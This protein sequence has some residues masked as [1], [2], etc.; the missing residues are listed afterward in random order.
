MDRKFFELSK[1]DFSERGTYQ[2]IYDL[3]KDLLRLRCEDSVFRSQGKV[4]GTVLSSEAFLLRFFGQ[5]TD[6]LLLVNLG[7][8]L[9][10]DPAPEPLLVPPLYKVWNILLSSED[11]KYGD[12]GTPPLDTEENLRISGHAAVAMASGASKEVAHWVI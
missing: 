2:A 6:R 3:H 1:L 10:L 7:L 12:M 8:G 4:E 5:S 11:R 9:H